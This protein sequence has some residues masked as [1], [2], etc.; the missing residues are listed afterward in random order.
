MPTAATFTTP[1]IE[2]RTDHPSAPF[3]PELAERT[4]LPSRFAHLKVVEAPRLTQ[5]YISLLSGLGVHG[6]LKS[7][8]TDGIQILTPV[9]LPISSAVLISI[10]GCAT[11]WAEV[12][13]CVKRAAVFQV[14]IVLYTR[15]KPEVVVGDFAVI[16]QLE[17]P[18]TTSRGHTVDVGTHSLSIVCKTDI[19]TNAWVR[20]E[21]SGRVLFG[22]VE[23][24]V[25]C[26]MMASCVGI[27]LDG[28]FIA[29]TEKPVAGKK[30]Q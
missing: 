14:G 3:L 5:V 13:S 28:V 27:H 12:H 25:A 29:E 22:R 1:F 21:S 20:V 4:A 11:V 10:A 17:N 18:F 30:E 19:S 23:R 6:I 15:Y 24:V 8:C 2:P 7:V 16:H 9:P 26:S